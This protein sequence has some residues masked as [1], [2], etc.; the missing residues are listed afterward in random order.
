MLF[1]LNLCHVLFRGKRDREPLSPSSYTP[2]H[3]C[4]ISNAYD[5][6]EDSLS[7]RTFRTYNPYIQ[8]RVFSFSSNARHECM[9]WFAL[10]PSSFRSIG[11]IK[12]KPASEVFIVCGSFLKTTFDI[13]FRQIGRTEH[14]IYGVLYEKV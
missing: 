8:A 7:H 9:S 11:T 2:K 3:T 6:Y 4:H 12:R 10:P 14:G 5:E 1:Y 13:V